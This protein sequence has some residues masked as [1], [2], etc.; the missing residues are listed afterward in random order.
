VKLV[1]AAL[2]LLVVVWLGLWAFNVGL[3]VY[4]ADTS[5]P[6]TRDCRYLVGVSVLKRIELLADRC[7]LA[8][9]I[10]N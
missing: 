4:S 9:R 8:R 3:L 1:P 2:V 10:G 6:K 7:P 5:I